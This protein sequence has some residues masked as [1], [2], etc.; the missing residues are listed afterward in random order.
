MYL[1]QCLA[2]SKHSVNV[3]ICSGHLWIRCLESVYPPS[4]NHAPF[5]SGEP[6]FSPQSM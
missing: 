2:L 6:L 4:D 3:A 5:P 1:A